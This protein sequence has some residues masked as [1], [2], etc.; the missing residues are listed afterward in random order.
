MYLAPSS[1]LNIWLKLTQCHCTCRVALTNG[2]SGSLPG[3]A[4]ELWLSMC[5]PCQFCSCS[6][7]LQGVVL[8]TG[9]NQETPGPWNLGR[10][11]FLGPDFTFSTG[12]N[13]E[14]PIGII[15]KKKR[16]FFTFFIRDVHNI[17]SQGL[18]CQRPPGGP[19]VCLTAGVTQ[20]L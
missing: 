11:S 15:F 20:E 14:T 12:T 6:G 18:S 2:F 16:R 19:G 10:F 7:S 5:C 17:G 9:A 3:P 8:V 4:S 13:H 1:S